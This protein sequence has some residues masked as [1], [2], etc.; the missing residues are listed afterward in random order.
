MGAAILERLGKD[1]G[2]VVRS[3]GVG[4]V[5]GARAAP[6]AIRT[7]RRHGLSLEDHGTIPLS[8]ELLDWADHVL[9]ME[10]HHKRIVERWGAPEKVTML[11][12]YGGDGRDIPDP[13]GEGEDKY[14]EVFH[15]L[16]AYLNCFLKTEEKPNRAASSR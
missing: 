1:R 9:V 16:D 6:E 13:I 12:E 11:S 5:H 4:A 8:P 2:V 14:E 10:G 7:A 15:D 3:A